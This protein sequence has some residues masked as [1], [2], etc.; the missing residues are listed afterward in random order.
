MQL[1]GPEGF[2][3]LDFSRRHLTL[4]QPSDALARHRTKQQPF[5]PAARKSLKT[6]LV[7]R[8]LQVL[9]LDCN[10][11]DQLT[12][13][14]EDFVHCVRTGSRPRVRGE[15]GRDAVALAAKV[16]QSIQDHGWNGEGQRFSGPLN[17]PPALGQLFTLPAE[18]QAA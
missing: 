11:G 14:L 1:W 16:V 10:Q 15:D 17:L 8:H 2:A 3:E 13:E 18:Q 7:G 4:V 6:D 5:D 12:R 9:E